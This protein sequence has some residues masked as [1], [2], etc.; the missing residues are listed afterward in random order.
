M[1]RQPA[2]GSANS[3][4]NGASGLALHVEAQG[5]LRAVGLVRPVV[6]RELLD[7]GTVLDL[8]PREI[9]VVA[10]VGA[11]EEDA[12]RAEVLLG[13]LLARGETLEVDD[14]V[15]RP[16]PDVM[17]TLERR[18]V[19]EPAAAAG[20]VEPPVGRRRRAPCPRTRRP[21]RCRSR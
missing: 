1:A 19:R 7:V 4:V 8:D 9:V 5:N 2:L 11:A 21:R 3:I 14:V 10:A 20:L 17:R 15:G 16:Q 13:E 12:V 6:P 18:E